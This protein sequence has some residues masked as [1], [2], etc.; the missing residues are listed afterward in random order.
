M[1]NGK[2]S[3]WRDVLAGVIQGS[4]LGPILF[5]LFISDI[6]NYIPNGANLLKYADDILA[7]LLGKLVNTNIPQDI[8]DGV[9]AWCVANKMRLN[10]QCKLLS[11]GLGASHPT[12]V[13]N[14]MP[15]EYVDC[16]KY[17]GV[18]LS[19]DLDPSL[20][21]RRVY[22]LVCS[23]PHLLKKLKQV[24]FSKRMLLS[25]YRA[26]GR[27]HFAYSAVILMSC[28][29]TD[30]AEMSRFQHRVLNIIG[31]TPNEAAVRHNIKPITDHIDDL[32]GRMFDRIISD[33][34]H[35]ITAALPLNPRKPDQF[36]VPLA[37]HPRYHNSFLV[38]YLRTMRD[39]R[40]D[41]YTNNNAKR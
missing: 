37:R 13:L 35:P 16:Y 6:N 39:G 2:P 25:V 19:A 4:V 27:S 21:W 18:E 22:S 9:Q 12:L 10:M 26:Y 17:L 36:V 41:L 11:I 29:A 7:Y 14:G 30:K 34:D 40:P 8:V 31:V 33:P 32:C 20:Q 1:Y 23:L 5:L 28:T 15:L 38:T 24:G 3:D